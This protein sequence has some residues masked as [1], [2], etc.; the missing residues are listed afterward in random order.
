MLIHCTGLKLTC[1]NGQLHC[2]RYLIEADQLEKLLSLK[3]AFGAAAT[4]ITHN[5]PL[6]SNGELVE[7]FMSRLLPAFRGRLIDGLSLRVD[8][9]DDGRSPNA[10]SEDRYK[11]AEVISH[12]VTIAERTPQ[13]STRRND[14]EPLKRSLDRDV[15]IPEE[16]VPQNKEATANFLVSMKIL[17]KQSKDQAAFNESVNKKLN[18]VHTALLNAQSQANASHQ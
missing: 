9:L 14:D 6:L 8:S 2:G 10:R 16:V 11:Y 17:L 15:I 7:H 12:A 1:T 4:K 3:R 5:P 13:S 18:G